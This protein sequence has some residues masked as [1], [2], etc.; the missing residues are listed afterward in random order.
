MLVIAGLKYNGVLMA[1]VHIVLIKFP[2]PVICIGVTY[3]A[4]A[5]SRHSHGV[6]SH[7]HLSHSSPYDV[8]R[9]GRIARIRLRCMCLF[10][11]RLV[12]CI[13]KLR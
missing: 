4:Q 8:P 11:A 1:G 7:D 10:G 6:Y 5:H 13:G 12:A 2:M 9:H 3:H